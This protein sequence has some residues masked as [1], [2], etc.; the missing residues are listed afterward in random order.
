[1]P[2][3][4][5]TLAARDLAVFWHPC[6]QMRDYEEFPPLEI[7]GAEGTRLRLSDGRELLDAISSWW[8]KSL[9]HGH[10]GVRAR[11]AAQ[12]ASFE[13]VIAANTTHAA[14][15]EL[16][17]RLLAMANATATATATATVAGPSAETARRTAGRLAKVFLAENGSTA[18][19]IALKMALQA[20]AQRGQGRRTRFAA[21][22]NGYH[23]ETIGAL[24]VGDLGLYA[25]PYRALMFPVEKLG[26]VPYRSGPGDPR[27][28]DAG[29]EWERMRERLE[30]MAESLAAIVYEPV[31]QAAGG[32]RLYSPDLLRRL[33]AFARARGIFLIADEIA[34][35]MARLGPMLAGTLA[36]GH[37]PDFVLLGK[38]LTAGFLPLAAVLTTDEVYAAF[39]EPSLAR[40]FLHSNT[41]TG[42]ALTVAAALGALEAYAT[43]DIVARVG[44]AGPH[45]FDGVAAL[46]RTR[47]HLTRVR[48]LG[49]VAALDLVAPDGAPLPAEA[50]TGYRVYRE[51]VRRGAL[52]RPLGDS[53]YLFPPLNSSFADLDAMVAILADSIDA[54]MGTP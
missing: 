47:P 27:W 19:E 11:I 22:E 49:M 21:L 17:E 53:M 39:Y 43:D 13:H 4:P 35:G 20:Q 10:P 32:M 30:L 6:S 18:V 54:V 14:L 37:A 46:A 1:V 31:L 7:V 50:R 44:V 28:M 34:A 40:G 15:V 2:D 9:G 36:A 33:G 51:A 3:P 42:N 38:G 41:H 24:S 5:T 25:E 16:C 29:P 48:G 26:P 23:G 8:C 12:L 52:L 45:L